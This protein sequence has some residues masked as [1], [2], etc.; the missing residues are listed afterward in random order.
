MEWVMEPVFWWRRERKNGAE[1]EEARKE[2]ETVS[3][4][5]KSF[6]ADQSVHSCYLLL[7]AYGLV[8]LDIKSH[9]V[10]FLVSLGVEI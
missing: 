9:L 8:P 2:N 10:A 4:F 7:T 5:M 1:E 3:M 6:S